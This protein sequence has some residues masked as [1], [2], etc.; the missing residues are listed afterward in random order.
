MGLPSTSA[1]DQQGDEFSTVVPFRGRPLD[2]RR[3][4]PSLTYN[5]VE[6][7][8]VVRTA[9]FSRR[10][11]RLLPEVEI[12]RLE[13]TIGDRPE[14]HPVIAGTG[15]I[16]K[17]RWARPGIGKRGGVR[18][19]YY[20]RTSTGIVYMLDI[21]AKNEKADLTPADKRALREMVA[22]LGG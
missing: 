5:R 9:T 2:Y 7:A 11:K 22:L 20:Y 4:Y 12:A 16:R 15:G 8:A 18:A 3:G 21:Y 19:V 13:S 1:A 10:A 17:A 6:M 14:D